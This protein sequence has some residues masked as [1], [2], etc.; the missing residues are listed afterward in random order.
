MTECLKTILPG[1][2]EITKIKRKNILNSF[3]L[4]EYFGGGNS[5]RPKTVLEHEG[6]E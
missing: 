1:Y 3:E 6:K 5:N 2:A 4:C